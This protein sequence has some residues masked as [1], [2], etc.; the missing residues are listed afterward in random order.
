MLVPNQQLFLHVR[1]ESKHFFEL[2]VRVAAAAVQPQSVNCLLLDVEDVADL[3]VVDLV[4][5]ELV[6]SHELQLAPKIRDRLG[7]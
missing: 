2:D 3:V 6:I 5:M 4:P 1:S 7:V